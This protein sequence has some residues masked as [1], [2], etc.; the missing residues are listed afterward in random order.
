MLLRELEHRK[1]PGR[2]EPAW[3]NATIQWRGHDKII[4]AYA[5]LGGVNRQ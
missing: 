4:A 1:Q 3:D 2:P 5:Y